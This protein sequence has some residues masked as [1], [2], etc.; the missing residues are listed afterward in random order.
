MNARYLGRLA[1]V[2]R[3]GEE[4]ETRCPLPGSER[5][6]DQVAQHR[7]EIGRVPDPDGHTRLVQGGRVGQPV[8]R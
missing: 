7:L 2:L 1:A 4:G 5:T 3:L 6:V 8:P